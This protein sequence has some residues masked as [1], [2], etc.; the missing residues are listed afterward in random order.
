MVCCWVSNAP[1]PEMIAWIETLDQ[2]WSYVDAA[3]QYVKGI[4]EKGQHHLTVQAN[5]DVSRVG[6]EKAWKRLV[7]MKISDLPPTL[8][9][10]VV[11]FK[12]F[13]NTDYDCLVMEIVPTPELEAYRSRVCE[14]LPHWDRFGKWT[15]H[16][17]I[18]YLKKDA[19][20]NL[21]FLIDRINGNI[22]SVVLDLEPWT[23]ILKK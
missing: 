1:K 4:I 22:S 14:I 6:T 2:N 18:G 10:S 11:G 13:E 5:A 19:R 20:K 3:S 9:V 16:I 23:S 21:E 8:D 15:P 12:F 17:T 7:Q